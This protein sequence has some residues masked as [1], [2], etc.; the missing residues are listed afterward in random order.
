LRK[1]S[2]ALIQVPESKMAKNAFTE[3]SFDSPQR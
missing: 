2:E 3:S 1:N